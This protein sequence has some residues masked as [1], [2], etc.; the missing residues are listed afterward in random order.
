[1]DR[2]NNYRN[3]SIIATLSIEEAITQLSIP[4]LNPTVEG[5]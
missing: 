5:F 4:F 3:N 2:S 1:M